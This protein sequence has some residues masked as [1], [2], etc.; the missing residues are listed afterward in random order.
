[1]HEATVKPECFNNVSNVRFTQNPLNSQTDKS[2]FLGDS[3]LY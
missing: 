2:D 3:G 1:M